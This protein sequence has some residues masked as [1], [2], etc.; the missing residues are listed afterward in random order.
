MK[1]EMIN[2]VLPDIFVSFSIETQYEY[3]IITYFLLKVQSPF[4]YRAVNRMTRWGLYLLIKWVTNSSNY[5][6]IK[7]SKLRGFS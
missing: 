6:L 3:F 2:F 7:T 5:S 4:Y 1:P